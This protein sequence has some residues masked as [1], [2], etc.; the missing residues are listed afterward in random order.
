MPISSFPFDR[1]RILIFDIKGPIAHFRKYYTNSSSLSYLF[2]PRTVIVGLIAG[3]LGIPSEKHTNIIEDTYYEKFDEK[4][5]FVTVSM[6]S[7][8]R[9]MMQTVNYLATDDFPRK[10]YD[11]FLK[12]MTGKIGSTQIPIELLLPDTTNNIIY[13]IYFYHTDSRIYT[14]LKR[15]LE[16]NHY[17]FPPYFGISELL[18]SIK[19]VDEGKVTRSLSKEIELNSVCKLKEI[20]L[21]FN[22]N[23][24]QYLTEKMPTVFYNGRIPKEPCVYLCEVNCKPFNIKLKYGFSCY[25]VTYLEKGRH[26]SENIMFM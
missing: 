4:K 10:T 25:S 16:N 6:R 19:Y 22:G 18:A 12:M 1:D 14:D 23:N 21:N 20:E 9:K 3:L 24:F 5:C 26:L 11:L 2:P 8:I 13:R 15:R 7:K 17:V